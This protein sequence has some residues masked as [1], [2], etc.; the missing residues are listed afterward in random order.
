MRYFKVL[1]L[2]TMG[3]LLGCA[4]EKVIDGSYRN[5]MIYADVPDMSV[6]RVG[7][8]YYMVSTTMHLMPG[9]PVM[10]SKDLVNWETVSYLFDK[11]TDHERYDLKNG[12]VYGKGQWATSIR[13]HNGKFYALFSPNDVPYQSYFYTTDDPT[14]EW[15]LVSR[16]QHFHD[17]S[18]L[19]DDEK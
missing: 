19:F 9:A 15:K 18:L 5:P 4:S 1:L 6:I 13:Y 3:L 12:S 14:K 16:M 11:L 8:Y 17:A 2:M 10:R 7:E